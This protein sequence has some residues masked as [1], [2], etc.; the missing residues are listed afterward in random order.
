MSFHRSMT[1]PEC[2]CF[3]LF[4]GLLIGGMFTIRW[5]DTLAGWPGVVW[6]WFT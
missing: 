5:W 6:G 2:G 3:F 1:G 4:W